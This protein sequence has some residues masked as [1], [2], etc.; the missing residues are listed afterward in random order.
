[1]EY[2]ATT[3]SESIFG[4]LQQKLCEGSFQ[5]G[6]RISIRALALA[7]GTSIMPARDAVRQ[8]VATGALQFIDS[9][10]IIVP[11]LTSESHQDILNARIYLEGELATKAF[12][13]LTQGDLQ[14]LREI[15]EAINKAILEK[16]V[17]SYMRNNHAF[18][19]LIYN[20]GMSPILLNLIQILWMRY[21]PS[22]R[23]ISEKYGA[24]N[25]ADDFHR[26]ITDALSAGDL[27]RFAAA[28]RADIKQGMDF[29]IE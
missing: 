2:E 27:T 11:K 9:R 21:G 26:E 28:I 23:F 14:Q 22:M 8:L 18:H 15:D 13:H 19:F 5:P 16:D 25:F 4:R 12:L 6:E 3:A 20:K 17:S 1:M 10:S 29:I 7:E 24:T